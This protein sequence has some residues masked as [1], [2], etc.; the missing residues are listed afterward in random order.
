MCTIIINRR[1]VKIERIFCSFVNIC[2][3]GYLDC[4][5]DVMKHV[6]VFSE[7]FKQLKA[8]EQ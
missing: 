1:L 2:K 3:I 7:K 4:D 5:A 6:N 8:Y